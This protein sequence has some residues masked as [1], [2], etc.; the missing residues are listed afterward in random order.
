MSMTQKR[1]KQ[2]QTLFD[3]E[4]GSVPLQERGDS[5]SVAKV[6]K[7]G[8]KMIREATQTDLARQSDEGPT[9]HTIGQRPPLLGEK[10]VRGDIFRIKGI[11]F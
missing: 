2:R 5:K 4:A 7:S 8:A 1:G 11:S 9:D 6:M 3:I 10:K